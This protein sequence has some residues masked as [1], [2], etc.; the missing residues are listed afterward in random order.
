[1]KNIDDTLRR[2]ISHW[3]PTWKKYQYVLENKNCIDIGIWKGVLNAMA[4]KEF[5]C[6]TIIGVEPNKEHQNDCKKF[7][8]SIELYNTIKDIP[9]DINVDLILMH[10]VICLM[11]D[12]WQEELQLLFKKVNAKFLHIRHR[13]FIKNTKVGNKNREYNIHNLKNYNSSPSKNMLITFLKK[14]KYELTID[15]TIDN[16]NILIFEK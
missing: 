12:A 11:G 7:Y 3:E 8:P 15:I 2:C 5:N 10:G 4:K 9:N 14:Y 6:N 13:N 16:N 1:M